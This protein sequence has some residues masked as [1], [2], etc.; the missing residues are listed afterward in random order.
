MTPRYN[1]KAGKSGDKLT[2]DVILNEEDRY[3][4]R[5]GKFTLESNTYTDD[6]GNVWNVSIDEK[7]GTVTATVPNAEEASPSTEPY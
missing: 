3:N 7:T 2:S 5:P 6:K 4:R 1:A